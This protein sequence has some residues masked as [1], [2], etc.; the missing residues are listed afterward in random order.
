MTPAAG[1]FAIGAA[2]LLG[3][4]LAKAARPA[5]T[6]NALRALG[7][8]GAPALV[9]VGGIAEA[10]IGA[11]ALAVGDRV[12]AALV[13]ASYAAFA[14]FVTMALQRR[15]P[16]SS[17]GCFGKAD[18][19]PTLLH[20][21]INVALAASALAVAAQPRAGLGDAVSSQPL[22]GIPYLALVACGV[23]LCYLALTTL[24]RTMATVR[25]PG[26]GR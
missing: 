13:A 7:L 2:L 1:P 11:A 8:P 24:P 15:T 23:G 19:P 21:V 9:R 12:T 14:V 18:T 10:V 17:C 22:A 16:L 4:G 6:A 20:V 25:D 26:G 5:D 3:A